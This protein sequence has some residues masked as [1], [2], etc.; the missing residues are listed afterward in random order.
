[1]VIGVDLAATEDRVSQTLCTWIAWIACGTDI[2]CHSKYALTALAF[3]SV[4]V[5]FSMRPAAV[6]LES[7]VPAL[8]E[9]SATCRALVS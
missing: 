2:G 4:K 9:L 3:R 7:A 1:M 5:V 6:L 8:Y